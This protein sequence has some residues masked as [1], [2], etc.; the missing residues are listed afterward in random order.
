[1]RFLIGQSVEDFGFLK[2]IQLFTQ[3]RDASFEFSCRVG[4]YFMKLN[5]LSL[6]FDESP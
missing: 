4:M 6:E 1:M 2:V 5:E 3:R